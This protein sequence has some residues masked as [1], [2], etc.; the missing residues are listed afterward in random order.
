M[1]NRMKIEHDELTVA[2]HRGAPCLHVDGV[3]HNGL[4]FW[5]APL[6][7]GIAEWRL[8][9]RSGVHFF[10]LD[11][12]CWSSDPADWE[13]ALAHTLAADPE[14][15]IWL[16]ISTAPTKAWLEAN[17]GHVQVHY[18]QA[19]GDEIRAFVSFAS[20]LWRDETAA[21]LRRLVDYMES[22]HGDRIWAYSIQEGDCGEWAYSW[23]PVVSGYAPVQIAAWREWLRGRYA[24]RS[25]LR[26]AWN[27][28]HADF[29]TVAPPAWNE[30]TLPDTWPATSHLIDP[31][32][33]RRL[34]DWLHFHGRAQAEA[35]SALA[36]ATRKALEE[37]GRRKLISAFHGYHFWP[38]GSAYGTCNAGFSDL[39]P[40]LKSPDIDILATP[41]AYIHRNPGGLYSHHDLAATI[42]LHGK[43]FYT[44][45][46]TFTHRASWTPWRYCSRDATDT[47]N[48]LRRNLAG[49]LTE[50]ATQWWMDHNGE[51]WYT[52]AETEA[53][54]AGMRQLADTALARDRSPVAE[55]ALITNE[56]SFRILRQDP[57]LIDQLWPKQQT[58]L[59][60]IGAPVDF[61]RVRDL[62]LAE[63]NGDTARWKFVVVAG[64]LWLDPE[65]RELLRR[66]LLRDGRHVLFLHAQGICDGVRQDLALAS[67]LTGIALKA[68]PHGGPCRGETVLDGKQLSWGTDKQ[69]TPI[70]YAEDDSAETLGWLE[71]QYY[72]VL[73]R[74]AQAGWT[75]LWSGV[76]G[77]PWNLLGRMAEAAGVHR[78][79]DDGSQVLANAG[80]LAVHPAGDGRRTLRLPE[81]GHVTD[82]LTGADCGVTTSLELDLR[83][84]QTRIWHT[85][86]GNNYEARRQ[87]DYPK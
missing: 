74:K 9:A 40:V 32:R 5:H 15:K 11:L 44:E 69:I 38:Y 24:D 48:I 35:L 61:V 83:R 23:K 34:V 14:A 58:E 6:E 27:D 46:D 64:C 77:V 30:R 63:R 47:L 29:A 33:E 37:R 41:L 72:P 73:M 36:K 31:G 21:H 66:T 18:D 51:D 20:P 57:A 7:K 54:I 55:I 56:A 4:A 49:A 13:A 67:E 3:P 16:R 80:L 2:P 28:P 1:K 62:A 75:A 82:A 87:P 59:L 8:F 39:D 50:G 84:G 43:L 19:N 68:Y 81:R 71:R 85:T 12:G 60:R 52:D 86:M 76:P 79:L 10:Q 17:P 78:Y 42:R 70:L 53:G 25:A 45:D 26:A 22:R 65:E